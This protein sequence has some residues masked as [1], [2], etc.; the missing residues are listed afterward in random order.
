MIKVHCLQLTDTKV[1]GYVVRPE[2]YAELMEAALNS[3]PGTLINVHV[4]QIGKQT[5]VYAVTQEPEPAPKTTKTK[6]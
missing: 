5:Y 4:K 1:P 2:K 6:T 3:L